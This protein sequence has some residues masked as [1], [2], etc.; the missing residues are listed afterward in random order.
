MGSHSEAGSCGATSEASASHHAWRLGL[1]QVSHS[2]GRHPKAPKGRSNTATG[3]R[4]PARA[5]PQ[6][7]PTSPRTNQRARRHALTR[8]GEPA[9]IQGISEAKVRTKSVGVSN[10]SPQPLGS[11]WACRKSKAERTHPSRLARCGQSTSQVRCAHARWRSAEAQASVPRSTSAPSAWRSSPTSRTSP[12][13]VRSC[14]RIAAN[15]AA[16][17]CNDGG[18]R[19]QTAQRGSLRLS[20]ASRQRDKAWERPWVTSE[21]PSPCRTARSCPFRERTP[22]RISRAIPD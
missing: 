2:E 3:V 12:A 16:L 7:S 20:N 1:G 15:R 19:S 17:G 18:N 4:S 22:H 13:I 14:P 8:L 5:E 9:P 11:P 21:R 6:P 10:R